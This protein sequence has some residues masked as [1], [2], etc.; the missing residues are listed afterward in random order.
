MT[1]MTSILPPLDLPRDFFGMNIRQRQDQAFQ[2]VRRCRA[3]FSRNCVRRR[4]TSTR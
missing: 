2:N 1:P 4:I 3:F